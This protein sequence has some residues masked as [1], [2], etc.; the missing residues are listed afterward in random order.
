V[1]ITRF[2]ALVLLPSTLAAP[3]RAVTLEQTISRENPL[4]SNRQRALKSRTLPTPC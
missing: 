1:K 3:S 4:C 2:F